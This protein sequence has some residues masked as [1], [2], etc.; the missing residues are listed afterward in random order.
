MGL[1]PEWA[2]RRA[3]RRSISQLAHARS[4]QGLSDAVGDLGVVL[5]LSDGGWI[6]IGYS[7]SHSDPLFSCAV[8]R[9]SDGRWLRSRTH[10]CGLFSSYRSIASQLVLMRDLGPEMAEGVKSTEEWFHEGDQSHLWAA[11]HAVSM[12]EAV[13]ELETIGLTEFRP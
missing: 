11:E 1:L 3:E 2:Y 8:A 7:D 13:R 9:T 10:Y 4:L 5:R 6:A 12:D